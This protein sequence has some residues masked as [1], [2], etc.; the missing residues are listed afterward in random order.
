M[1]IYQ[2]LNQYI[3][4]LGH[5][6]VWNNVFLLTFMR[7]VARTRLTAEAQRKQSRAQ[8]VTEILVKS[9]R[10]LCNLCASAVNG[11]YNVRTLAEKRVSQWLSVP[12]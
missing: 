7:R 4:R 12:I 10:N 8:R 11:K 5:W 1:I 6:V 3:T 2:H 9:L